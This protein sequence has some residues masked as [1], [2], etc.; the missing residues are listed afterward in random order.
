MLKHHTQKSILFS[1][2]EE[3]HS[4]AL[5]TVEPRTLAWTYKRPVNTGSR[6]Q[7]KYRW[8]PL[9]PN[10]VNSKLGFIRSHFFFINFSCVN[11]YTSFEIWLIWTF[12]TPFS[13]L[14][15]AGPLSR[16][17]N[18]HFFVHLLFQFLI[19][20][21]IHTGRGT[22]CARKFECFSFDVACLQCG[23][24]IHINRS[25]LL[26]LRCAS[27]PASC[28]DWASCCCWIQQQLQ[29]ANISWTRLPFS[30]QVV[31][32]RNHPWETRTSKL[33]MLKSSRIFIDTQQLIPIQKCT[34]LL[35]S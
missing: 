14:D 4:S 19:S 28:V 2:V 22:R 13:C 26:A 32:Y 9:Y 16:T 23:H 33:W 30:G 27:R 12:F 24:P 21:F 18:A 25:H 31:N 8:V 1:S 7:S 20:C 10:M 29:A 11:P 15:K 34:P 35:C 5:F 3:K 17:N 6:K